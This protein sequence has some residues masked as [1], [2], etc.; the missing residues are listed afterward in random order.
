VIPYPFGIGDD[1][2]WAGMDAGFNVTCNNSFNPPRLYVFGSIE[3]ISISA[4]T[5]EMQ[6]FTHPAYRCYDSENTTEPNRVPESWLN[7]TGTPFL[8]SPTQN[9]FTGIGCYAVAFLTGREDM[10]YFTGC[11]STC[12]SSKQVAE[13]GEQCTGLGCCQ[14]AIPGNLSFVNVLWDNATNPAWRYSPCN[15][16]FVAERNWYVRDEAGICNIFHISV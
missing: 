7:T 2:Y 11:I 12:E 15:Y 8:I 1:C 16:G 14:T 5:S 6:I 3:V 9:V 13:E 10:S 4:E